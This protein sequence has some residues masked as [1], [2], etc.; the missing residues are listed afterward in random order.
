MDIDTKTHIITYTT[1][2]MAQKGILLLDD[3]TGGHDMVIVNQIHQSGE[4]VLRMKP[5]RFPAKKY[6]VGEK[7]G[8]LL[9]MGDE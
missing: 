1:G 2:I 5:F 7:I 6:E 4:V 9:I 8:Q 3:T